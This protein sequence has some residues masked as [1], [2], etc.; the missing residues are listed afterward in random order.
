MRGHWTYNESYEISERSCSIRIDKMQ[1]LWQVI[2]D[3]C[4]QSMSRAL[5]MD[6]RLAKQYGACWWLNSSQSDLGGS[7]VVNWLN[8]GDRSY[9]T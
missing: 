7:D 8:P 4:L 3:N 1:Y 5:P 9:S 6:E 2:V